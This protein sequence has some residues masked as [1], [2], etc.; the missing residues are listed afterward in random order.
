M[1]ATCPCGQRLQASKQAAETH[2]TCPDC[3]WTLIVPDPDQAS[4]AVPS[5]AW[6]GLGKA[7]PLQPPTVVVADG[8][9]PPVMKAIRRLGALAA[10]LGLVAATAHGTGYSAWA[11]AIAG[12]GVVPAGVGLL[13][14]RLRGHTTGV[15]LLGALYCGTIAALAL[16][17][18]PAGAP[19]A[20]ARPASLDPPPIPAG[21]HSPPA[22]RPAS[23]DPPIPAGG[24]SPP[25]DVRIDLV[26]AAIARPMVRELHFREPAQ[27][28]EP[29]LLLT[30][31][32]RNVGT[33]RRVAY[34][35]RRCRVVD[36]L[37]NTYEEVDLGTDSLADRPLGD[38]R[39]DPGQS[40]REI[41]FFDTPLD[42]VA[43]LDLVIP[44]A[45]LGQINPIWIPIPVDK[46]RR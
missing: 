42:Q 19:R 21:G 24:H 22:A 1:P 37:G 36:D 2:L 4:D 15:P 3:G 13:M 7:S 44:G 30:L 45:T 31:E 34:E 5:G 35:P 33:G 40:L 14:A 28:K 38:H 6:S 39:I 10:V 11:G 17:A 18:P 43:H 25:K 9:G 41:L 8:S 20:S 32:I 23:L 27:W 46:I 16:T 12:L 29:G 26:S